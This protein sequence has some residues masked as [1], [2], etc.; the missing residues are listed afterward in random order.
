[1]SLKLTPELKSILSLAKSKRD[2]TG[3]ISALS[4]LNKEAIKL[5]DLVKEVH[6]FKIGEK[7]LY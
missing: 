4:T 1:L 2:Y 7:G 3:L 6:L 5:P